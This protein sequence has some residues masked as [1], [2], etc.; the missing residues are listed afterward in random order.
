[1]KWK[2]D[3]GNSATGPCGFVVYGLIADTKEL[4]LQKLRETFALPESIEGRGEDDDQHATKVIAYFNAS[5]LTLD[6]I[7]EDDSEED[8]DDDG[9]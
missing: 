4:A 1:M 2:V 5:H 7:E 3:A 8:A 9:E 6:D